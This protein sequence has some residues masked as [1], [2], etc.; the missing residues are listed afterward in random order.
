MLPQGVPQ[1]SAVCQCG[2]SCGD[3]AV[4]RFDGLLLDPEVALRT[5]R[6]GGW[7]P[8]TALSRRSRTRGGPPGLRVLSQFH[9]GVRQH[10]QPSWNPARPARFRI[11]GLT[12]MTH[13]PMDTSP[14]TRRTSA[15]RG[16]TNVADLTYG[17]GFVRRSS[18]G[19]NNNPPRWRPFKAGTRQKSTNGANSVHRG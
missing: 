16:S 1:L 18:S 5:S 19:A 14:P 7:R 15:H 8:R 17:G 10:H 6:S 13:L 11:V 3:R 9:A 12:T 4:R 2:F